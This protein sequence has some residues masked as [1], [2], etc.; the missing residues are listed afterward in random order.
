MLIFSVIYEVN[1][2]PRTRIKFLSSIKQKIASKV[3]IRQFFWDI[4]G[5]I[6]FALIL[7]IKTK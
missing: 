1:P 6:T 4:D 7:K 5:K 2:T 3:E